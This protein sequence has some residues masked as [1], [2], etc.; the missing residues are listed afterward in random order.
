MM[1][2][3]IMNGVLKISYDNVKDV[4]SG[5]RGKILNYYAA[6]EDAI[7]AKADTYAFN[8]EYDK[9]I[10]CLMLIPEELFDLHKKALDKAK[11]IYDNILLKNKL[12]FCKSPLIVFVIL[13]LIAVLF[14]VMTFVQPKIPLFQDMTTGNYCI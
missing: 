2:K 9:A 11:E 14:V 7:F 10:A 13:C 1:D 3:A 8:G 12:D 4:F 6:K 5:A